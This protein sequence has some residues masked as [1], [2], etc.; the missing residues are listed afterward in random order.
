[1]KKNLLLLL[2]LLLLATSCATQKTTVLTPDHSP[3]ARGVEQS[4][5]YYTGN[6]EIATSSANSLQLAVGGK[7]NKI[8]ECPA[9]YTGNNEPAA[10]SLRTAEQE[11]IQKKTNR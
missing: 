5:V 8:P 10:S 2:C 11:A 9:Y 1:M 7:N 6:N 3:K 4:P